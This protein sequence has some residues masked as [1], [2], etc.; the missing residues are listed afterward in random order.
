MIYNII[1]IFYGNY[2]SRVLLYSYIYNQDNDHNVVS[3]EG[4][5]SVEEK[6][7]MGERYYQLM[8]SAMKIPRR[9]GSNHGV[10]SA[11]AHTTARPLGP[12]VYPLSNLSQSR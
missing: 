11:S 10:L 4:W 8:R 1:I 5:G 12:L 9:V 6:L 2:F 7:G 3:V